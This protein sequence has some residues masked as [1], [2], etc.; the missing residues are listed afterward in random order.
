MDALFVGEDCENLAVA[1][2]R[3]A[4]LARLHHPLGRLTEDRQLALG[5]FFRKFIKNLNGLM[6]TM[7]FGQNHCMKV[8]DLRVFWFTAQCFS[9]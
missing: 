2:F 9:H 8:N 1:I 5:D 3:L 4:E 7:A 6:E